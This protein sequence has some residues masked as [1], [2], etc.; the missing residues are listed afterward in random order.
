MR[1]I[2]FSKIF[3]IFLTIALILGLTP[4]AGVAQADDDLFDDD[5]F[6]LEQLEDE[7]EF[8]LKQ[9][10]NEYER[11]KK[12]QEIEFER[13]KKIREIEEEA[14][15]KDREHDDDEI[16]DDN[17]EHTRYM[18]VDIAWG[19]VLGEAL[20]VEKTEFNGRIWSDN[21]DV[22]S[23]L[24]DDKNF[25]KNDTIL[26]EKNPPEWGSYITTHWDGVKI[27]LAGP[28]DAIINFVIGNNSVSMTIDELRA[29]VSRNIT[30]IGE[31]REIVISTHKFKTKRA[32]LGIIWGLSKADKKTDDIK[33]VVNFD[34]VASITQGTQ[35]KDVESQKFEKDHGDKIVNKAPGTISWTSNITRGVDGIKGKVV[36]NDQVNLEDELRIEFTELGFVQE[37]DLAELFL[38]EQTTVEIPVNNGYTYKLHIVTKRSNEQKLV[39]SPGKSDVYLVEDGERRPILTEGVFHEL[40]LD[41]NDVQ[42]ITNEEMNELAD[43]EEVTYPDG[44]LLK[45]SSS[46]VFVVDGGQ[47]RHIENEDAFY[48][49][50][51]EHFRNVKE[52]K[53][54]IIV[55][56]P[57]IE[58]VKIDSKLPEGALIKQKGKDGIYIVKGG[59]KR[60]IRSMKIFH[61]HRYDFDEVIQVDDELYH[62]IED[63]DELP[64][65]D[66]SVLEF[67]DDFYLVDGEEKHEIDE[68]D[69]DLLELQDDDLL[70]VDFSEL[71]S[72]PTGE[73]LIV[74]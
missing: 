37:F 53:D 20:N 48:R 36:L 9:L 26:S 59:K 47:L 72:V 58:P 29:L 69:F 16:D 28:G 19:N 31:G 41:F 68:E 24:L 7:H 66:G 55:R 10:E 39:K 2:S 8:R 15:E 54:S 40:E 25:E 45:G 52:V 5:K 3:R 73:E 13:I 33:P 51:Y 34:G 61:S 49:L 38:S 32:K 30:D 22:Q 62:E 57:E 74:I 1:G 50:G 67:E 65:A 56:L 11:E 70:E 42:E 64:F 27:A 35:I 43:G 14:R 46:R 4:I 44:T 60:P 17:L 71:E 23:Y 21:P 18:K 12:S 6:E 63:G